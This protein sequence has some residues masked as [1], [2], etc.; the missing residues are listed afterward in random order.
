MLVLNQSQSLPHGDFPEDPA[1]A[2]KAFRLIRRYTKRTEQQGDIQDELVL[3]DSNSIT[4]SASN[5]LIAKGAFVDLQRALKG[6]SSREDRKKWLGSDFERHGWKYVYF[7]EDHH[8]LNA[9]QELSHTVHKLLD[10][11]GIVIPHRLQPI[12]HALDLE[13]IPEGV[14]QERKMLPASFGSG[15]V[16]DLY[17]DTDSCCD[18]SELLDTDKFEN[19][20]KFWWQCGFDIADTNLI[21]GTGIVSLAA[22]EHSRK[23]IPH[24]NERGCTGREDQVRQ[25]VDKPW[26]NLIFDTLSRHQHTPKPALYVPTG[27]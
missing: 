26:T 6:S 21:E 18:T 24:Q 15:E 20:G 17:A 8:I 3:I 27:H 25:R 1:L 19:C 10:N 7:T 22:T 23:C 12:P 14:P 2:E 13:G 9:R 11:G 16:K 5:T 4:A